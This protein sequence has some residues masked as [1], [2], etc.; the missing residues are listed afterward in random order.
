MLI[1]ILQLIAG[2]I[3]LIWGADRLVTGASA[4]ARNAGVSPLVIGLTIV[5]F[6]TSAPELVTSMVASFQGT[7]A[8]AVGNAI[9]SNIANVGLILGF[10]AIV[11]PVQVHSGI[12]RR[13]APVLFLIMLLTLLLM[14]NLELTR[15]DGMI[16]ALA[17]IIMTVWMARMGL[18]QSSSDS[19]GHDLEA[20]IP[21][22][23]PTGRATMWTLLG[24]IILPLSSKILVDGAVALALMLGVPEVIVGL[25]II[26]FGTSLPELAAAVASAMK[27][28]DDLA[29]GNILGSNMFNLL[30]VLGIAALVH[31]LSIAPELL[32]R[33]VSAMFVITLLF[34]GLYF[35]PGLPGRINRLGGVILLL[36][37]IIY[38]WILIAPL[39]GTA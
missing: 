12:L 18:K 9:G 17:L 27:Q 29:V 39:V 37:F 14:L 3:L 25:T 5:G 7:P 8:L 35:W 15:F 24:L 20:E 30:G 10:T 34:L 11:Y 4:L 21:S 31:P 19:L 26:A 28:E 16:L 36:S 38:Q 32:Y 13:E 22:N 2:F 33:D 23:M 1:P 6:G